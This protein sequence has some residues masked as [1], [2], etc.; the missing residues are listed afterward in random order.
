[1]E[2]KRV[3]PGETT[4]ITCDEVLGRKLGGVN[5]A[6]GLT[7]RALWGLIYED[8]WHAH[9]GTRSERIVPIHGVRGPPLPLP[10]ASVPSSLARGG[11]FS[12]QLLMLII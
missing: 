9:F 2:R 7:L 5:S 3:I 6:G 11:F 4:L 1:M 8:G 12:S 10:I